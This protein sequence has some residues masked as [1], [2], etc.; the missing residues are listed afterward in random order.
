MVFSI[1]NI[2][3]KGENVDN[4]F[5]SASPVMFLKV[6]LLMLVKTQY[7]CAQEY[8]FKTYYIAITNGTHIGFR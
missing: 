2:V 8:N 7:L 5:F 3:G 6:S 4:L 1:G